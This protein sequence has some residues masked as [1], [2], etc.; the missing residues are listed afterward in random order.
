MQ[1]SSNKTGDI[2]HTCRKSQ[3]GHTTLMKDARAG[4][5]DYKQ[6]AERCLELPSESSAPT[7]AESTQSA[8]VGLFDA[9]SPSC[10]GVNQSNLDQAAAEQVGPV[11]LRIIG[12]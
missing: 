8:C 5:E 3:V 7:V 10:A 11:D 12:S 6:L 1:R 9:R 2:S 4:P